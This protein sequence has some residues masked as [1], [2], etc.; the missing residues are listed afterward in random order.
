MALVGS[1]WEPEIWDV[2]IWVDH[3]STLKSQVPCILEGCRH[4]PSSLLKDRT[5][6]SMRMMRGLHP[7]RQLAPPPH[8]RFYP[9]INS[10][11]DQQLRSS[12]DITLLGKCR[13]W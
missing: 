11:P 3:S 12:Q 4:G 8:L 2:D 1:K 10:L 5:P 6:T 13:A 7:A 9:H